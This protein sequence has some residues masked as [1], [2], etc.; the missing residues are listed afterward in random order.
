MASTETFLPC[1]FP[2]SEC[3]Y[4]TAR[5]P[6]ELFVAPATWPPIEPAVEEYP[7]S[8]SPALQ[9]QVQRTHEA[10]G[11]EYLFRGGDGSRRSIVLVSFRRGLRGRSISHLRHTATERRAAVASS[12]PVGG[13]GGDGRPWSCQVSGRRPCP[14]RPPWHVLASCVMSFFFGFGLLLVQCLVLWHEIDEYGY[15]T[16]E[17]DFCRTTVFEKDGRSFVRTSLGT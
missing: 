7:T 13:A 11:M 5:P 10:T 12:P 14:W 9:F 4:T 17:P 6:L 8:P 3:V 1:I 16:V 2:L 15:S